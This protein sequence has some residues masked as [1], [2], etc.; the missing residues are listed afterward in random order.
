N[1]YDLSYMQERSRIQTIIAESYLEAAKAVHIQKCFQ[2]ILGESETQDQKNSFQE[3]ENR[4]SN[5]QKTIENT[6]NLEPSLL[7]SIETE[8]FSAK[9]SF[10]LDHY[11]DLVQMRFGM[12]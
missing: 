11:K 3:V 6:K 8:T 2:T 9:Y 12:N 5:L 7:T 4:F 1:A 10:K